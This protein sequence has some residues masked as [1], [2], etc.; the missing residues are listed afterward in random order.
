MGVGIKQPSTTTV[1]QLL[2]IHF[3]RFNTLAV[4]QFKISIAL[5]LLGP[6]DS[7]LVSWDEFTGETHNSPKTLQAYSICKVV[8]FLSW[9]CLQVGLFT[10]YRLNS[11]R[12]KDSVLILLLSLLS[13][14]FYSLT[15]QPEHPLVQGSW[16]KPT[17]C[18]CPDADYQCSWC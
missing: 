10:S 9:H 5:C 14:V 16:Q 13:T 18:L 8:S 2:C 6:C 11:C 4:L 17:A 7:H 3:L 15:I 12:F 1:F